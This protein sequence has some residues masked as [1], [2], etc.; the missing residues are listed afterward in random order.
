MTIGI[1][2]DVEIPASG[3]CPLTQISA[4]K[5]VPVR[6]ESKSVDPDNP[7][8]VT[9]EF[10]ITGEGPQSDLADVDG[11]RTFDDDTMA[12]YRFSR[13]LDGDCPCECIESHGVP[14]IDTKAQGDCLYLTFHVADHAQ[15]RNVIESLRDQ[16]PGVKVRRLLQADAPTADSLVC[17]DKSTLTDRQLEV[18]QTAHEQGYFEHPRGAN[19][20]EVAESLDITT[21]TFVQHLTAAQEKI[22]DSILDVGMD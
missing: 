12:V 17:F 8:R 10:R 16:F 21:A 15:L 19:A 3:S 9:E 13:T 11:Q 18:L 20:G 14:V 2:V 7:D 4:E 1:R 5:E 6:L 22:L